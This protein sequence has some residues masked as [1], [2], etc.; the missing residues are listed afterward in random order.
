ME[1]LSV[2]PRANGDASIRSNIADG[3]SAVI[4]VYDCGKESIRLVACSMMYLVVASKGLIAST[5]PRALSHSERVE[6]DTFPTNI[7]QVFRHLRIDPELTYLICCPD[8]FALY[9]DDATAPETC[10]H[11][12]L[13]SKTCKPSNDL[14]GNLLAASR[15]D[16]MLFKTF[17]IGLPV[18]SP[19]MRL[20][21]P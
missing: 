14:S 9:P 20:K 17:M 7:Q 4:T 3:D 13:R 10:L 19:E 8:C 5:S 15:S 18:S 21:M 1:Q 16:I 2:Q 6:L 11:R 12:W